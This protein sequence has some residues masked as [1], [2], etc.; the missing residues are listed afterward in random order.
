MRASK[1]LQRTPIPL[2]PAGLVGRQQQQ[3]QDIVSMASDT[4]EHTATASIRPVVVMSRFVFTKVPSEVG[5][6]TP[7]PDNC[8]PIST[9]CR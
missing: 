4:H 7:N 8:Q 1:L 6:Y 2:P 3:Q 5:G 9:R